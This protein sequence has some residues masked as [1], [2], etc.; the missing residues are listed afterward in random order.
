ML[1]TR[2]KKC[3]TCGKNFIHRSHRQSRLDYLLSLVRLYPFRC[4]T[5]YHRFRAF[6]PLTVKAR[7]AKNQHA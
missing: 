2:R 7:G 5:C 1:N 3:P 6:V 4:V